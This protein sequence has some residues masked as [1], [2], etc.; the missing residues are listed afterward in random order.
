MD[1]ARSSE[2]SGVPPIPR[3]SV[4]NEAENRASG[5]AA[6]ELNR[7]PAFREAVSGWPV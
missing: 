3:Y 4:A 2:P 6:P 1:A 7:V 5:V